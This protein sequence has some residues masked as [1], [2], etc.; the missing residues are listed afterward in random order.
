MA[1]CTGFCGVRLGLVS[2]GGWAAALAFFLLLLEAAAEAEDVDLAIAAY[3]RIQNFM[4]IDKRILINNYY[5]RG[6]KCCINQINAPHQT[7]KHY[8]HFTSITRSLLMHRI[9]RE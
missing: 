8:Q 9:N 1:A 7:P 5:P 2:F 6:V 3:G 4:M